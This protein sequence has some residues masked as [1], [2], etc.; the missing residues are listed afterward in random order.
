MRTFLIV[1]VLII[2]AINVIGF[3]FGSEQRAPK[4]VQQ[5]NPTQQT[6]ANELTNEPDEVTSQGSLEEGQAIFANNCAACHGQDGGGVVAP[7]LAGNDAL[8]DTEHVVKQ[9]L[10]GGGSMPAFGKRFSDEEI[11]N[12]ASFIRGSWGNDFGEVLPNEVEAER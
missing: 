5:S 2:L 7:A 3:L 9:I 8:S 4:T 1:F 12:V 6:R 11:A 10:K